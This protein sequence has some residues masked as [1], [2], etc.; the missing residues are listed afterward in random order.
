LA[1][2]AGLEHV[3]FDLNHIPVRWV[4]LKRT[5]KKTQWP[6]TFD[7]FFNK[8]CYN[9]MSTGADI[10]LSGFMGDPQTG[11]HHYKENGSNV[12]RYFAKNQVI[13]NRNFPDKFGFNMA[14]LLPELPGNT[15][16]SDHQLLDLG[17]RQACCIAPIIS[18]KKQWDSWDTSLGKI[19]GSD[20]EIISPFIHSRW[21]RYWLNEPDS[22]KRERKLYLDF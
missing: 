17:V 11:G 6:Y 1:K 18:F 9:Q 10:L 19:S 15:L 4:D 12:P 5:V 20:A 8:Y 13:T 14:D 16:F 7:S 21:I 22:L 2:K 3:A